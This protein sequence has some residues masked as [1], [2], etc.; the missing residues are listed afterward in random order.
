M[1]ILD[2]KQVIFSSNCRNKTF[3]FI[4]VSKKFFSG[5]KNYKYFIGYSDDDYKTKPL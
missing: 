1:K 5:E 2:D 3:F 4:L